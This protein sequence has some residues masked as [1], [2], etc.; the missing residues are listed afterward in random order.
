MNDKNFDRVL[1]SQFE[2]KRT[3]VRSIFKKTAFHDE[4]LEEQYQLESSK[5]NMMNK[6]YFDT[7]VIFCYISIIIYILVHKYKIFFAYIC[8]GCLAICL[9]L[10]ASSYIKKSLSYNNLI[11]HIMIFMMSIFLNFKIIYIAIY[12]VTDNNHNDG[13]IIRA[14]TYDFVTKNI[15]C[16][17]AL[18]NRMPVIISLYLISLF[19]AVIA[20]IR[21]GSNNL[22]IIDN[23]VGLIVTVV[24]MHLKVLIE[25]NYRSIFAEKYLFQ[26]YYNYSTDFIR[27]L[28]GNYINIVDDSSD[29]DPKINILQDQEFL[30]RMKSKTRMFDSNSKLIK[31][32]EI[33]KINEIESCLSIN[34]SELEHK[35]SKLPAD[36]LSR[37]TL[38]E[39]GELFEN[40]NGKDWKLSDKIKVLLSEPSSINFRN[41]GI[42]KLKSYFCIKYFEVHFRKFSTNSK[43]S[44]NDLMI[45]DI[46]ELI[47]SREKLFEELIIKEKIIIKIVHGLKTPLN[48]IIGILEEI[49]ESIKSENPFENQIRLKHIDTVRNLSKLTIFTISDIIH[50]TNVKSLEDRKVNLELVNM[51]EFSNFGF[52][53]LN[54]LL[55]CNKVKSQAITPLFEFD[56]KIDSVEI[57]ADDVRLKQI[58]LNFVSNAV[59]FTKS[60]WIKLSCQSIPEKQSVLFSIKD[61]GVGIHIE[62]QNNLFN[63]FN[64]INN[65]PKNNGE[66]SGLGLWICRSL[67]SSMNMKTSVSSIFG[68]GSEFSLE[69]PISAKPLLDIISVTSEQNSEKQ[70]EVYHQE[71]DLPDEYKLKN[72]MLSYRSDINED[73]GIVIKELKVDNIQVRSI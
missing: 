66:G 65:D 45:Y 20:E 44:I 1:K 41:I 30:H 9:V 2:I 42:Y 72:S 31:F 57:K 64:M 73:H 46:T 29:K 18:D 10:I 19:T 68:A 4:Q 25:V 34:Y 5:F 39:K 69:I 43:N 61:S 8:M 22:Y 70:I 71:L 33:N 13:E 40:T 23:I 36:F 38:Y 14:L 35:K 60:G 59:K 7:F 62:D 26:N 11:N 15:L 51:R 55:R 37:F 17:M 54:S 56:E 12:L 16:L 63:D 50:F 52:D 21:T 67:A 49:E 28:N 27:G 53:V 32:D 24:C 48:S 58:I 6:A 3:I 47:E